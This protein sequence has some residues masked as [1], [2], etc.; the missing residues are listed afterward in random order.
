MICSIHTGE[1]FAFDVKPNH[2]HQK[3]RINQVIDLEITNSLMII[4]ELNKPK[5][6]SKSNRFRGKR[7]TGK[8]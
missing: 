6:F 2:F 7:P 3:D 5:K 4:E 8:C 1:H